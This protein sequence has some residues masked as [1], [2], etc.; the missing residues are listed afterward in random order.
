MTQTSQTPR[1]SLNNLGCSFTFGEW[2]GGTGTVPCP[3][4]AGKEMQF[5]CEITGWGMREITR[6]NSLSRRGPTRLFA[7]Y[8]LMLRKASGMNFRDNWY[9]GTSKF[10]GKV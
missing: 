3:P 5:M 6:E 8:L 9:S 7:I 2:G 10:K 1:E 4:G